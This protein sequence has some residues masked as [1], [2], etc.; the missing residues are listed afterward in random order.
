M[1]QAVDDT[2]VIDQLARLTVFMCRA[3]TAVIFVEKTIFPDVIDFHFIWRSCY[4]SSSSRYW[5]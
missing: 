4:R 1:G 3:N 2:Q 5:R